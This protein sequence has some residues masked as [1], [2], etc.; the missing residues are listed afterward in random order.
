MVLEII[1][2]EFGIVVKMLYICSL[3][4]FN[5]QNMKRTIICTLLVFVVMTV[6]AI[7]EYQFHSGTAVLKGRILNKPANE[8]DIVTVYSFNLFTSG[9]QVHAIPVADDGS[10]EG[11]IPLAH[12]QSVRIDDIG[13]VFLAVGDTVELTKD[14]TQEYREGV[15]F[16]GNSLSSTINQLWPALQKHYFGDKPLSDGSLTE[17]EIPSWKQGMAKLMDTIIA[18]IKADR[19]PLSEGT[20]SFVK[21]VLGASLLGETF[22]ATLDVFRSNMTTLMRGAYY[23]FVVE[24]EEW[25]LDNP[26][27][28]FAVSKPEFLVNYMQFYMMTDV[29]FMDNSL[30]IAVHPQQDKAEV[31]AYKSEF[32]LPRNFN[33][34]LHQRLLPLRA[35]SLLTIADYYRMATESIRTGYHLKKNDFLLQ[36]AV[37][38]DIFQESHLD[39]SFS[40][41]AM[42]AMFAA[43][44]PIFEHPVVAHHALEAYRQYVINREGQSILNASTTP[45]ADAIFERIIAPYKGNA[46]YIDFWGMGCGPC[47]VAMLDER[48]KV[49]RMK[50]KPVR[51]LYICDEKDS[52]RNISEQWMQE[53]NIKG[54]H[55]YVTH[56]E[57]KQLSV[58][59]QFTAIPF[60]LALDKDGNF[61]TREYLNSL[62]R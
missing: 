19:L 47:R 62:Y 58:K 13:D 24:R 1:R 8:W 35:D 3:E 54:E 26:A 38:R 42:A 37:C 7:D 29:G 44:I 6:Q 36:V 31:V 21:E 17:A 52:P 53:N 14:A 51:F 9:E 2:A 34:E 10:F 43:G 28:M 11:V 20:N 56:E 50:E 39:K 30:R 15:T 18:D 40:P 55:I 32:Y 27:M 16:G 57:W 41:D 22:M 61:V 60:N 4:Y 23:D 12:S 33:A 25:L 45:E 48:E 49:E 59:F 5:C 46:L